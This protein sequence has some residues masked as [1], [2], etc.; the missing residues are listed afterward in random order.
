MV[1]RTCS[2][3]STRAR[4]SATGKYRSRGAD[5]I[6]TGARILVA[7]W[8]GER[9]STVVRICAG[10]APKRSSKRAGSRFVNNR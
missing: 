2:D 3:A 9:A 6:S 5:A 1:R 4:D 10:S 7:T 8:S